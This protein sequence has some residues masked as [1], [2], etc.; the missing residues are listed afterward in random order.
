MNACPLLDPAIY[1]TAFHIILLIRSALAGFRH[2][3]VGHRYDFL[4]TP[5]VVTQA[6][7]HA[8]S[9]SQR[10][11]DSGEVVVCGVDR[12]HCRMIL[13]FFTESVRQSG[14]APHVIQTEALPEI[15]A[16][17]VVCFG[18]ASDTIVCNSDDI[19]CHLAMTGRLR[20]SG[21][22]E[23]YCAMSF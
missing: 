18:E 6:S 11:V 9:D 12:N 16:H 22:S 5:N 17:P 20:R 2:V 15:L 1:G 19:S 7:G 10:L 21:N 23:C 14:E 4:K 3:T 8:R 13:N